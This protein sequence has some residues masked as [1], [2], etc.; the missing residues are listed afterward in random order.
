MKWLAVLFATLTATPALAHTGAGH[1]DSLS[2][3]L[4]HPLLGLDH[5]LAMVLVGLWAGLIGGAR[6]WAWPAAFVT[7]MVAGGALGL[8]GIALPGLEVAIAGSVVALGLLVAFSAPAPVALGAAL[9]A[10][11]GLAHGYAHG[12]EA[13]GAQFL[14]YV[15]GFVTATAALHAAGLWG[16][17]LIGNWPSRIAGGAAALAGLAMVLA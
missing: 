4:L 11:L 8:S 6:Q 9:I 2:A 10:M 15:I 16:G 5:L 3:G 13:A 14:S 17:R 12:A 1:V 7:A